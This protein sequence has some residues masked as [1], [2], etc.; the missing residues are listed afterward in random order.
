MAKTDLKAGVAG[1]PPAGDTLAVDYRSA[2]RIVMR[3]LRECMLPHWKILAVSV[4]AMTVTAATSGALPFLLQKVADEIFVAKDPTLLFVLP[5]LIILLMGFR[6]FAEWVA[7]VTDAWLGTK[8]VA[9]LRMRM[10]DRIAAADLAWIQKT[11]SG[12][13]VSAFVHDTPIVD[14][15]ATKVLTTLFKNGLSVVFLLGAMFYMDWRLSLLVL[16]GAPLGVYNLSRQRQRIRRSVSRSLKESGDLGSMLT[17]TLQSMRIVKAYSQEEAEAVR[18]RRVVGNLRKYL[19]KTSRSRASVGPVSDALT[20]IGLAAAILYGGWQGIYGNVSLGHFMG[21]LAAA[22]LAVQPLK[23]LATTQA[24]LSEGLL[25]ASR[26]FGLIDHTSHVTEMSGAKPLRVTAGAISL[27]NVDFAYDEGGPVLSDLNLEIPAGWK[28]A[29]VGHSGTGKSTVLN[30][31][32]RFFDPTRGAILIDGQNLREATLASV[33]GASALLTQ[34]PVIFDDTVAA[35]ISYGSERATDEQVAA[36]AQAAAAHEFIM[37]LPQGYQTR[38]GEAGVRLSGGERQRIAFARAMLRDAPI[39]LLDEPTSALDA[40]SEAKVQAAMERLLSGR[41]V[42]MIAHRLAT[43]KKADLICFMEH[44]RIAEAG[45]HEELMARRGKY[46]RMANAQF[47]GEE[48]QL[49]VV[50]G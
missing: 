18:F 27:R 21:F 29:L 44:G 30:L 26:I 48:P 6:A 19:M 4:A 5:V 17:Q 34:D 31:I 37:R 8:I 39:L 32:L 28:V 43:V 46:A 16:M 22:M 35:N 20:G 41:T 40:E 47:I 11:H 10:F 33:R 14:R 45:T 25:A 50:G 49:A 12:R 15:A 7:T 3:L 38:V 2:W 1:A 13:F 42:V 9:D 23:S 24:V 36:A